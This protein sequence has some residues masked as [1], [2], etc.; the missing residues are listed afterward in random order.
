[1]EQKKTVWLVCVNAQPPELDT[2]LRHQKFA[3][4]L[5][6]KGYHV[7]FFAGSFLHYNKSNSINNSQKYLLS[8]YGDKQYVFIKTPSYTSNGLK[9]IFSIFLF[10][11]RLL[12]YRKKFPK[13]DIVIHNLRVPFDF[14]VYVAARKLKA[15]YVTEVWDL[16][17]EDFVATGL[18]KPKNPFIKIAYR[19]EKFLYEKADRLIFTI[20][21]GKDYIVNKGWD[22]EHGGKINIDKYNYI[23]NG[24]DLDEFE[25]NKK[26]YILQDDDL[27]DNSHF[28]VIYL[29][30]IRLAN[31]IQQLI[32]AAAFLRDNSKIKFLIYG[33][34]DERE[35][36]IEYCKKNN[37]K[38]VIFKEKWVDIKYVPYILSCSSLNLMNYKKVETQKYGGSQG[39]LFQYLASGKPILSNNVMGYDIVN[40]YKAGIS[41][42]ISNAQEYAEIINEFASLDKE[43][44]NMLCNNALKAA[45]FFDYKYLFKAYFK[46]IN[47]LS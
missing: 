23:N 9:R 26:N 29:G 21:G 8:K 18:M 14:P 7:I 2:H 44:Y 32:D 16:W 46:L 30:S 25:Y 12:Y 37:I 42:N 4:M 3:E 39:K 34:G 33:D 13:P 15:K 40:K 36:L 27:S 11:W 45:Q 38:N 17:P 47:E 31:N 22:T 20:E 1:M 10:A 5:I 43:E 35:R 6:K 28:K 24:I 41:K 19:I